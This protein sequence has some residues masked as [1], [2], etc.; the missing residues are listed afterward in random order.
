MKSKPFPLSPAGAILSLVALG[1]LA[2]CTA[3][4]ECGTWAFTGTP[5]PYSFQV[6]SAFTFNP[7][8]CGKSCTCS[9]DVITQMVSVYDSDSGTY[10]YPTSAYSDRAIAYGWS[11]DQLDGW[12]YG[13]YG[14]DND[15]HTFD[16]GYNP[17][18]SNGVATT[19]YDLP[20]W[21]G[22][23][24]LYFYSVDVVTCFNSETCKNKILGYYF[25]SWT[26]DSSGT[27]SQFIVGP[28]WKDLDTTFQNA[29][30]GWNAWAPTSGPENMG[31][32]YPGQPTLPNAVKFP[33]LTDL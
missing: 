6:S 5:Q 8:T 18:G 33:A 3:T 10:L 7:A 27:V 28:A 20:N 24:N 31:P 29:V 21:P 16:P 30:S 32:S 23:N 25:W 22:Y 12:A 13:Y 11:I 14:L 4:L 9:E 26:T 19:L 17:P 15:G 2:A 1:F